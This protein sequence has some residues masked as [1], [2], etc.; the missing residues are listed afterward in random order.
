MYY[1]VNMANYQNGHADPQPSTSAQNGQF[2]QNQDIYRSDTRD[3]QPPLTEAEL[4]ALK[5]E[6]GPDFGSPNP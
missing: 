4:K 5:D 3:T 6:L 1:G 2:Q